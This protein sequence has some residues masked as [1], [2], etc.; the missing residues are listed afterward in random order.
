MES[1]S[2]KSSTQKVLFPVGSP[3]AF[4]TFIGICR[5]Y[6]RYLLQ[7]NTEAQ[8]IVMHSVNGKN[9]VKWSRVSTNRIHIRGFQQNTVIVRKI[10]TR[11]QE[12]RLLIYITKSS[13]TELTRYVEY[14]HKRKN[15]IIY[16]IQDLL[17]CRVSQ[18]FY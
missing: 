15:I 18:A 13:L 7:S 8:V 17:A 6:C 9:L 4:S 3:S 16:C 5:S 10:I 2:K 12:N 11:L 14:H 1:G